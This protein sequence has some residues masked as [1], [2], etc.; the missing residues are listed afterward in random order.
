MLGLLTVVTSLTM[1]AAAPGPLILVSAVIGFAGTVIFPAAL[2]RL[3]RHV[4]VHVPAWARPEPSASWLLGV[5]GLAYAALA[6]AYVFSVW[7]W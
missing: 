5:A 4:A 7:R 6:A 2:W 1:L 3:N